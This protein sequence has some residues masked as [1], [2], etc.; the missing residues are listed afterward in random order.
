[1]LQGRAGR[2]RA[3]Q[4]VCGPISLV[5]QP[6]GLNSGQGAELTVGGGQRHVEER[7]RPRAPIPWSRNELSFL[8]HVRLSRLNKPSHKKK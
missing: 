6:A 4:V 1:M 2:G 8:H 3:G 5:A 7:Q